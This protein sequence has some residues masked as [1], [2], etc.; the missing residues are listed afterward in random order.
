MGD[1][2]SHITAYNAEYP[3]CER[4]VASLRVYSGEIDPR[5]LSHRLGIEPTSLQRKGERRTN[6]LGRTRT[7]ARNAWFISSE[8]KVKSRDLRHHLDW[9]LGLVEEASAG[10]LALQK[11]RGVTMSIDC[12]WWS[13]SGDGGPTLWPEQMRRMADLNL[14]C[15]FDVA[16]FGDEDSPA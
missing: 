16:F 7:I 3:T 4:T 5:S 12:I 13:A 14:E 10:L 11:K 15:S 2:D 8:G 9:L 1:T 6:S